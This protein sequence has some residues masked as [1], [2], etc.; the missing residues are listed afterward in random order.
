[1]NAAFHQRKT[2]KG[3]PQHRARFTY[4]KKA[5]DLVV[6]DPIAEARLAKGETINKN[7]IL[8]VSMGGPYEDNYF[9]FVAAVI[10]I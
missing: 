2:F 6:T 7:C 4:S 10:E 1:M 3:K 8:T 9:K 5:Y